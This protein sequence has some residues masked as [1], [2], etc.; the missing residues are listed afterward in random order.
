MTHSECNR[1]DIISIYYSIR[2]HSARPLQARD[3]NTLIKS[4]AS[5]LGLDKKGFPPEAVSSHYL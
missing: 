1:E 3:T 2:T 5:L 4:A